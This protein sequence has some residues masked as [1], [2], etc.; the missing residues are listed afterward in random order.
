M[1]FNVSLKAVTSCVPDRNLLAVALR[2]IAVLAEVG[3]E[4]GAAEEEDGGVPDTSANQAVM[5]GC[6]GVGLHLHAS[7][8]SSCLWNGVVGSK[9]GRASSIMAK[10]SAAEIFRECIR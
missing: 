1:G 9:S 7:K 10:A 3:V 2:R 8:S 5:R 6:D 4:E